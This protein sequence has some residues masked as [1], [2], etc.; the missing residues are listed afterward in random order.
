MLNAAYANCFASTS[1][2]QTPCMVEN[3]HFLIISEKGTQKAVY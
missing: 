2:F 3:I 1:N